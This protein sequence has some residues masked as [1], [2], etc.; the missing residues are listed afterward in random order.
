MTTIAPTPAP[1]P[2]PEP[3]HAVASPAGIAAGTVEGVR[4]PA[5]AI[6]VPLS[7]RV[8]FWA[9]LTVVRI[10]VARQ[11]RGIRLLILAV[12][13][14]LPIAIAVLTRQFQSPYDPDSIEGALIFGLIFQ[15][16]LP[17]SALL[18][19]SGMV[20]D[21]IE[22][23]TLTYFL[24]RPIPRWT[25]YLAKLLG[26]F[27]VTAIRAVIFTL[28]TLVAIYWGEDG[29]I[30]PVLTERAPII[31]A[32]V[33]LSL[34][35]Y[36]AIFGGLSLWVRRSL[37]VGAAYIVIF[38]GVFSNIDFVIRE[39]TVMYHIRVLAVR[40]LDLPGVDW[41]IDLSTA[42][43]ASTCLIVL[44]TVSALFAAFAALT[45]GMREFRVKTPEG[46]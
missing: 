3:A 30:R 1:S 29:L 35:A 34:S 36:V 33:A 44:L 43:A 24:I 38:E 40:W 31:V 12:L 2:H 18:F 23:Q 37:V 25:I 19:A 20:Q 6:P 46:S 42:P 16:L 17:V 26:T 22:E 27:V 15:A 41:S 14:S 10:T 7:H 28:A 4:H 21:D 5:G 9:I 32:L 39:A 8:S 11:G 13:F 45:F